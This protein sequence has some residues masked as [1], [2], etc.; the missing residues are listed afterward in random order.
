MGNGADGHAER[1]YRRHRADGR[2]ERGQV[3]RGHF[4]VARV[5]GRFANAELPQHHRIPH[6]FFKRHRVLTPL[7]PARES[8]DSSNTDSKVMCESIP[9]VC[10]I[11]I[12]HLWKKA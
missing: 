6:M 10:G 11:S 7:T 1:N 5:R 3:L 12:E 9:K 8:R 2:L 4:R